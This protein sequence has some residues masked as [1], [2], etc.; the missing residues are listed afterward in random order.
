LHLTPKQA[1]ALHENL[2]KKAI[3]I[4]GPKRNDY[5]GTEVPFANFHKSAVVGVEAWRGAMVRLMDKFSRLIRLAEQGGTGQVK[6][7]SLLDTAADAL[8]YVAISLALIIESLPE[9]AAKD[10][11]HKLGVDA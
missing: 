5:S 9:E 1:R 7:E 2:F 10:V 3:D 6:D 4:M 8:N 11:L